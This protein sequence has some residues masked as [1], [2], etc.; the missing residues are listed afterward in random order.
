MT[1]A[2]Q[3]TLN[4]TGVYLDWLSSLTFLIEIEYTVFWA[5]C[6]LQ[7]SVQVE[8]W[9]RAVK[10]TLLLLLL[11][12]IVT[13]NGGESVDRSMQ[14]SPHGGSIGLF[15]LSPELFTWA[16]GLCVWLFWKLTLLGVFNLNELN[17]FKAECE[18]FHWFSFS[19]FQNSSSIIMQG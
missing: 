9:D 13:E 7:S 15:R 2:C 6:Y 5:S 12:L 1:A 11:F 8:R 16:A 19:L 4:C 17:S 10:V 3:R 18:Q 14:N